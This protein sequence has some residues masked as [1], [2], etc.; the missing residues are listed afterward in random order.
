MLDAGVIGTRRAEMVTVE[1]RQVVV[2]VLVELGKVP[3]GEA[4]TTPRA[5][6]L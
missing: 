4:S 1:V 2:V 3:A 6:T 5:L